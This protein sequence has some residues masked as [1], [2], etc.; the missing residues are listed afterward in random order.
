[1][2][3]SSTNGDTLQRRHLDTDN[4]THPEKIISRKDHIQKLSPTSHVERPGIDPA[5]KVLRRNH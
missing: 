4:K 1:M 2:S 3:E 5:L